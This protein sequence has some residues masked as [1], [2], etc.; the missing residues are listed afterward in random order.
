MLMSSEDAAAVR[1]VSGEEQAAQQMATTGATTNIQECITTLDNG[2]K[3]VD[4]SRFRFAER[5]QGKLVDKP[6]KPDESLK[7]I[8]SKILTA[9]QAELA[10]TP[11][12]HSSE[13]SDTG[14]GTGTG[15]EAPTSKSKGTGTAPP[16]TSEGSETKS[17]SDTGKSSPVSDSTNSKT[18][19]ST[20][21]SS[22]SFTIGAGYIVTLTNHPSR[23]QHAEAMAARYPDLKLS[24]LP[25]VTK[26]SPQAT[27]DW[28][29]L[30][31]GIK[32][33]EKACAQ[34]HIAAIKKIA[35]AGSKDNE[36]HFVF[37]DDVALVPD[38]MTKF[39]NYYKA[40][41]EDGKQ[42]FDI[43]NL[44][45]MP[46]RVSVATLGAHAIIPD[47]WW[48]MQGYAMTSKGA[49]KVLGCVS[50]RF[51]QVDEMIGCCAAPT[52][53][54]ATFAGGALQKHSTRCVY[55][56]PRPE[57]LST[58]LNAFVLQPNLLTHMTSDFRSTAHMN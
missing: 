50:K 55:N 38:F 24:I 8:T 19:S 20:S 37:E 44:W 18:G 41:F 26:D 11:G 28:Y 5:Q 49:E 25:A 7:D 42:P 10:H 39:A 9:A 45:R 43:I 52:P 12:V 16:T 36:L 31:R 58:N 54:T 46:P 34:S 47:G 2:W 17:S 15:S 32:L 57:G 40:T 6:E 27:A 51:A 33:A 48:G 13:G 23:L 14:T 35:E 21:S 4:F 1:A 22:S 30:S 56:T 3:M 53:E 29:P